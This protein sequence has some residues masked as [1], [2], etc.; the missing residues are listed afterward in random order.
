MAKRQIR[1][2][3]L[4]TGEMKIDNTGNPDEQRI[5]AELGELAEL[6]TGD[7]K[8]LEVEQ[9]VHSHGGHN[10]THQHVGGAS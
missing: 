7:K 4:P 8:G 1:V 5:L 3:I 10:H 6:L 2:T 9:H